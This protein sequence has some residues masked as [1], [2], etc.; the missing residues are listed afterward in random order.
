MTCCYIR[1]GRALLIE[2]EYIFSKVVGVRANC[3]SIAQRTSIWEWEPRSLSRRFGPTV[4][5]C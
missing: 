1:A 2:L 3:L 5:P 4:G